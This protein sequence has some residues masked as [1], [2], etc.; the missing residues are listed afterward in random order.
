MALPKLDLPTYEITLPSNKQKVRF[1]PFLTK[2]QKMLQMA[3]EGADLK[4]IVY[5]IRQVVTNCALID[6]D[7]DKMPIFDLE[8][9]FLRLRSKS[10]GEIIQAAFQCQNNVDGQ[11]CENVVK[12]PINLE[13]IEVKFPDKDYSLI[14]INDHM[15]IKMTY[16][17]WEMMDLVTDLQT[18]PEN[19]ELAFDIV[20]EC[21]EC[22][23]D[24]DTVYDRFE[25][26]EMVK[27]LENLPIDKFAKVEEFLMNVPTLSHKVDFECK[28]CGHKEQLILQGIEAFFG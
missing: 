24:G 25:T 4:E 9:F 19:Y 28:K 10:V 11:P 22:V 5:A 8:Y 14:Q 21:V 17:K 20:T 16:P 6:L 1:R 26:G 23:Y 18:D 15:G 13:T 2:E 12:I 3:K 7:V 27:F